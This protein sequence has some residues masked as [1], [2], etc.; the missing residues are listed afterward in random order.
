MVAQS[1][2]VPGIKLS[3][4]TDALAGANGLSVAATCARLD[5]AFQPIVNIHTGAIFGF[6]ALL[7]GIE[8]LGF[9]AVYDL[10]T[11]ADAQGRLQELERALCDK[12]IA[13]FAEIPGVHDARLLFNLDSRTLTKDT[14]W[15][16]ST[17]ARLKN[18][19]L[20]AGAIC[21]E[22][23]ELHDL[24][25]HPEARCAIN[26]LRQ[27][28]FLLAI[29]DFGT[30]YSGLKLL[31]EFPPDLIKIDR[32][33]ISSIASDHKRRL[34]VENTVHLAHVLGIQVVAE[35]VEKA[36]ELT[37]CRDIGCD[38]V[39]GYFIARPT[40]DLQQLAASYEVVLQTV[41]PSRRK[42]DSDLSLIRRR[43]QRLPSL[44][45]DD[46]I[47]KV[48]EFFERYSNCSYFPVLD[49]ADKP[50]GLICE[51]DIKR[52]IYAAYGRELLSNRAY[53]KSI[54]DFVSPCPNIDI[55]S[56]VERLLE[57][58]A[59]A[60]SP[61]GMIMTEGFVYAGFISQAALLQI[62]DAKNLA[63]ARDQN[64]LTR[65]PGNNSIID[66]V[67]R[68]LE[69]EAREYCLVYFDFDNFKPFNDTYGFRV[70]DR[71]IVL[72]AD[73]LRKML[74]TQSCFI[75]HVGGDDFFAGF[76]GP[77]HELVYGHVVRLVGQFKHEVLS[78]YDAATRERGYI[79]AMTRDGQHARLPLLGVSAAML[80][81]PSGL[82][83]CNLD[84]ISR[85]IAKQKK[86][87][88]A[89]SDG[90]AE[91]RLERSVAHESGWAQAAGARIAKRLEES[92]HSPKIGKKPCY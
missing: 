52:F 60:G 57:A 38:L 86:T 28:R 88:K 35:G 4:S 76:C 61:P 27:Q 5:Y 41:G 30:G 50:L 55:N 17:A 67:S 29:D 20:G 19:G 39:Q 79:E 47:T 33:F 92:G 15:G 73:L 40:L 77:D 56:P 54:L 80:W 78:L 64:P 34:F 21:F 59:A 82:R 6:E 37:A 22:L 75:G 69:D 43:I 44:H 62:I 58:Y 36:S 85:I 42:S 74:P 48:F 51:K 18:Q 66:Y 8:P 49:R 2:R 10:F 26:R 3:G 16:A 11:V 23:S 45:E 7:R 1:T 83:E 12:A 65:L 90:L 14:N 13:R 68:V 32:F 24:T 31:Y 71:A 25:A 91:T 53:R 87:A 63:A 81:I 72:F 46:N 70:G 9:T 84:D 89:A